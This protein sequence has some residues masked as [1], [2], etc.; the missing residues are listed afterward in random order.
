MNENEGSS[1]DLAWSLCHVIKKLPEH[2]NVFALEIWSLL[3]VRFFT[4]WQIYMY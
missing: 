1:N 4:S 3:C 2:S